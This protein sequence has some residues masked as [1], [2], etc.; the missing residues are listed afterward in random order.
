MHCDSN[1]LFL[2]ANK[3]S[4]CNNC[5]CLLPINESHCSVSIAI[6]CLK[7]QKVIVAIEQ[8]CLQG[9]TIMDIHY[10]NDGSEIFFTLLTDVGILMTKVYASKCMIRVA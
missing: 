4:H 6:R 7:H 3:V 2:D 5:E 1:V 10:H 9:A 8:R